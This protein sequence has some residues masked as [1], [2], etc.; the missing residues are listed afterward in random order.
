MM[1]LL[2]PSKTLEM[3]GTTPIK[4]PT[5]PELLEDTQALISIARS[6][7]ASDLQS[8]MDISDKLATLN[9]ARFK[10]FQ[11][12]FTP[13][14]AKPA[15]FAFHGDVYDGLDAASFSLSDLTYA[16]QHLRILSGL[17]GLLKPFDLMQAYRLE[18]GIALG[19]PRGKNLYQFWGDRLTNLLN[20]HAKKAKCQHII[21]LASQEYAA[22]IQPKALALPLIVPV[23]KEKKGGQLKVI[24]L[25]AK[26]ARGRMAAWIIR[27]RVE[28]ADDLRAFDLDGYQYDAALSTEAEITFTR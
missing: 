2:S 23:F 28:S 26:R 18:M 24:G 20:Q 13:A 19:N 27:N 1:I 25:L 7:S 22:A 15:L 17:Y 9:A 8:L 5:Q 6:L 10:A 11:L 21:N 4:N 3:E 14:N 16:Q 12:P